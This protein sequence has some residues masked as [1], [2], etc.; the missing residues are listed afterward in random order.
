[1][2]E[3]GL[4]S[5]EAANL[6]FFLALG[7]DLNADIDAVF[8]QLVWEVSVM[9]ISIFWAWYYERVVLQALFF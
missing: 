6:A 3:H 5:R 1:M 7:G 8:R 2:V 4:R 9:N